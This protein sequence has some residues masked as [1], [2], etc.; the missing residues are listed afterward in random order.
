M[1][2]FGK[3]FFGIIATILLF[4]LWTAGN[5]PAVSLFWE[6]ET[7]TVVGHETEDWDSGWGVVERTLPRVERNSGNAKHPTALLHVSDQITDRDVIV[8]SWPVGMVVKSRLQPFGRIAY[9]TS[10]W[11]FMTVPAFGFTTVLFF[12]VGYQIHRL[13]EKKPRASGKQGKATNYG[14][15]GWIAALFVLLFTAVPVLLLVFAANFG[16]P[17]PRSIIWP[18]ETVEI[19]SS[20]ARIFNV[21]NGTRAAYV[22]VFV[23]SPDDINSTTEQMKGTTYSSVSIRTAQEIVASQ[24][25]PGEQT[26]AM[27]SPKGD[28]YVVKLRFSDGFAIIAILLSMLCF[29]VARMLWRLFV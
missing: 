24:Y 7:L 29:F 22:D 16:D 2:L 15:A 14:S 25:R 19:V 13:F 27:R 9:P 3:V 17:P 20:E 28:L 12:L 4:T 10:T 6:S 18:R 1:R 21:G 26:S 23:K 11:P 5:P 8:A